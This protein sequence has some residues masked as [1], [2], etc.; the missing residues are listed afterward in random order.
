MG[1]VRAMLEE[2]WDDLA[3]YAKDGPWYRQMGL[4][5]AATYRL[6]S[7][8]RRVPGRP[9]KFAVLGAHKILSMPWWFVRGVDIPA[10][11]EIGPG[12]RLPHPQNILIPAGAKI[13]RDCSIYHDVTLGRGPKEGVPTLGDRVMVFSGAKILGGVHIGDDA[14]IGPNA[15]VTRDVPANAVVSAPP[16]RIIPEATVRRRGEGDAALPD[17]P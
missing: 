14:R 15:V 9:A 1:Y 8:V 10:S 17:E 2:F 4:W 12:L 7:L 5:A 6:G 13:G 11:A 16:S 3:L